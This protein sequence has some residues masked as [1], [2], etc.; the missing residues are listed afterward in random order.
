MID[1]V[2]DGAQ[3]MTLLTFLTELLSQIDDE[4]ILL[5][6]FSEFADG[7]SIKE[8][9]LKKWL[10]LSER[11]SELLLRDCVNKGEVDYRRLANI[12]K[13]GEYIAK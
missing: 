1:E 11:D 6:A 7:G 2:G 10:D 12:M 13:H 8:C 5:E 3:F 4:K 9:D